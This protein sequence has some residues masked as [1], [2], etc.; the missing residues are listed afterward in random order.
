[1]SGYDEKIYLLNSYKGVREGLGSATNNGVTE[2]MNVR[3]TI[4]VL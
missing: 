3:I 4:I 1:M 2:Y